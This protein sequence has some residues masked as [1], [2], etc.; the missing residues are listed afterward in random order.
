MDAVKTIIERALP[1][2][3]PELLDT[4][5]SCLQDCGV[6][7]VADLELLEELDLAGCLKP[8]QIRKLL[9]VAKF[10]GKFLYIC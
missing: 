4:V 2:L 5:V 9:R 8:I 7:T 1:G 3:A 6:E 10:E